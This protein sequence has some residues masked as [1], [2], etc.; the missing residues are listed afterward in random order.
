MNTE[1]LIPLTIGILF[2]GATAHAGTYIY[3]KD[4]QNTEQ[5]ALDKGGCQVWAQQQT[6]Y[7]PLNSPQAGNTAPPPQQ[8]KG[9]VLRGA[10]TGAVVGEIVDNDAG[11]GAAAGAVIGGSRQRRMNAHTAQQYGAQQQQQ[12]AEIAAQQNEF[13]SA[14]KVCMEGRGYSVSE[15]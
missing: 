6:G 5:Q 9:G 3:A 13:S 14:F 10:A 1:S 11:K 8:H 7:D 12:Q 4:G 15:S 2:A